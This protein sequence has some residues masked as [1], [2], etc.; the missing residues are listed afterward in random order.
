MHL[1]IYYS[2]IAYASWYPI[3]FSLLTN[4]ELI[5][6]EWFAYLTLFSFLWA[7]ISWFFLKF[8]QERKKIVFVVILVICPFLGDIVWLCMLYCS[9]SLD[10]IQLMMLC[11]P[12]LKFKLVVGWLTSTR[13]RHISIQIIDGKRVWKKVKEKENG[14]V[15]KISVTWRCVD[16]IARIIPIWWEA[17]FSRF[18]RRSTWLLFTVAN[19]WN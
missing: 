3:Y 1:D 6:Y 16:F 5:Y 13:I 11:L 10:Y 2:L 15:T 19:K 4:I 18:D 17:I 12:H 14:T 8:Q 9:V 7:L